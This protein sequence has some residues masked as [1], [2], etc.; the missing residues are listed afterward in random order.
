MGGPENTRWG[1]DIGIVSYL[2]HK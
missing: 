2:V 1:K